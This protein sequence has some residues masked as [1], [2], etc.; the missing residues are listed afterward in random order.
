MVD[1]ERSFA[2]EPEWLGTEQPVKIYSALKK[3]QPVALFA[4][5]TAPDGYNGP[6]QILVGIHIDGTI[7]GV[8]VLNHKETPGLSDG[9]DEEKS[10]WIL[11]FTGRSIQ[12]PSP[13]RWYL[14]KD[15]G[16]FDQYTGATIT[17]RAIVRATSKFLEY[18]KS[19]R[20]QLFTVK[21]AENE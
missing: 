7:S 19:H 10:N 6:I 4:T 14:K 2:R 20:E 1:N 11:G 18:F 21:S 15:G 8:R 12:N 13:D 17:Q 9:I 5:P 16:A 3:G